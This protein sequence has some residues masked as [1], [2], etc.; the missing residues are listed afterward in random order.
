MMTSPRALNAVHAEG[1]AAARRARASCPTRRRRSPSCRTP[2]ARHVDVAVIGGGPAGLAARPRRARRRR[3]AARSTSRIAPAA[4]S[5]RIRRSA[6]RAADRAVAAARKAGVELLLAAT[7]FAWYPEDAPRPGAEPGLLAVHTPEGLL[8]LTRRALRLRHRRLRS[9]RALRRQ[10]SAGRAA[11]AR[12]RAAAGALRHQAGRAAGGGRRRA[13]RAGADRRARRG[14]RRGHARRRRETQRAS[15]RTA[16]R[17]CARVETSTQAQE[18]HQVR[19]GGGGR[20]ARARLASCRASTASRS[21]FADDGGGFACAVD[22]DGRTH[23]RARL[24][25]RRR[26]RLRAASTTPT[27]GARCGRASRELRGQRGRALVSTKAIVCRCE[28]VTLGRRPAHAR[29]RLRSASRRSSATPASAPARARAR[30]A[31]C[32]R[33]PCARSAGGARRRRAVHL[34]PAGAAGAA[35]HLRRAGARQTTEP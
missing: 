9:E 15:P 24:R 13:L 35:R 28:D 10:R 30:S 34:A 31:W 16:T 18:A 8:K 23:V 5:W 14:R 26:D 2:R 1:R 21:S 20:P 32:M 17:G 7:A 19:P 29:A 33:A 12:G 27:A 6:S 4:R 25:L 11:G 3:D 22:E